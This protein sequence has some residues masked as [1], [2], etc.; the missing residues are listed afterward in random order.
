ML[1]EVYS[2]P[3]RI[4]IPIKD[5]VTFYSIKLKNQPKQQHEFIV[6]GVKIIASSKKDAIKKYNHGHS[7][8]T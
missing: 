3:I 5:N 4:H 2:L 7:R 6:K 1:S 8:N